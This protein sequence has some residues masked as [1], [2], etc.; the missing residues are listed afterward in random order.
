MKHLALILALAL[1]IAAQTTEPPSREIYTGLS[2]TSL[3]SHKPEAGFAGFSQKITDRGGSVA[4]LT[5]WTITSKGH[6][7]ETGILKPVMG[8][9]PLQILAVGSA[10]VVTEGT[11]PVDSTGK[12][13][14]ELDPGTG[15]QTVD[16]NVGLSLSTGLIMTVPVNDVMHALHLP[17]KADKMK[18]FFGG[19]VLHQAVG[20]Q[21]IDVGGQKVR[22]GFGISRDWSAQ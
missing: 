3:G 2:Y 18:V 15:K 4:L 20:T 16:T 19:Q 13:V 8:I 6:T 9:G 1:P 11:P 12:Q 22:I 5:N 14:T 17:W 21:G 10:G 7:A